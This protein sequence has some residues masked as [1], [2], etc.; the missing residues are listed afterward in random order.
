M[1]EFLTP[2]N[3]LEKQLIKFKN[4]SIQYTNVYQNIFRIP[5]IFDLVELSHKILVR[6]KVAAS[7][8]AILAKNKD[9]VAFNQL[10]GT[11]NKSLIDSIRQLEA[12]S[13]LSYTIVQ[14][15]FAGKRDIQFT[16]LINIIE[17]GFGISVSEF[18]KIYD[19]LSEEDLKKVEKEI[20]NSKKKKTK[21]TMQKKK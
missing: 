1:L 3:E 14:G 19:S 6:L 13:R 16:S 4:F 21:T 10:K 20:A 12:S 7:L 9:I 17:E 18:A 5:S 2:G 8:R 15:V 11:E